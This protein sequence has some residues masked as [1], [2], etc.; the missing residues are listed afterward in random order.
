LVVIF[1]NMK[2]RNEMINNIPERENEQNSIEK[3][4]AQCEIYSIAKTFFYIQ[5]SLSVLL[6]ILLSFIKLLFPEIDLTLVIAT[7]SI[8]VILADTL[9]SNHIVSLK[10]AAS[11]IQEY[12]DIYVLNLEWNNILCGEKPEH[13]DIYKYFKKYESRKNMAVFY[14]WYDTKIQNVPELT[15]K[16]ICQKSNCIYDSLIRNKYNTVVISVGIL[17]I[18]FYNSIFNIIENVF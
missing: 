18:F 7:T 17:A 9:L 12:F 10:E 4:A 15:G 13:N 2:K 8:F 11:K 5:T 6:M 16:I 3:L 1:Q 14:N